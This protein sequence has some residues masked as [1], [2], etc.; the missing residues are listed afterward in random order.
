MEEGET[1]V[2]SIHRVTPTTWLYTIQGVPLLLE[3]YDA[4]APGF[5]GCPLLLTIEMTPIP[6]DTLNLFYSILLHYTGCPLILR[7]NS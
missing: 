7:P 4:P 3:I 6:G 2:Y 1:T 5:P